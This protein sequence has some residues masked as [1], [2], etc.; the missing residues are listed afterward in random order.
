[1]KE[2]E[3]IYRTYYSALYGFLL[4]LPGSDPLLAEELTQETFYQ[5]FVS[6]HRY[7]GKCKFFTWLCQ[8][9]KNSYFKYLQKHK[10]VPVDFSKLKEELVHDSNADTEQICETKII[11]E[12]L[13][14][15]VEGLRKKQKDVLILRIYFELSFKEISKTL[16]ITEGAAKVIYHRGKA[17]LQKKLTKC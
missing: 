17:A 4:R 15:A 12:E 3:E 7:N 10:E 1:M 13:R 5:A 11:K 8:I 14:S 2:F 9:A 6:F 16:G